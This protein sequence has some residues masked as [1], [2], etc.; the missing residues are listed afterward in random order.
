[1]DGENEVRSF[2]ITKYCGLDKRDQAM[3]SL[4]NEIFLC[5]IGCFEDVGRGFRIL[6]KKTNYIA[7]R[8]TA[9]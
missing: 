5:H 9:R 2:F 3:F 7:R 4:R 6:I 1:M 8:E